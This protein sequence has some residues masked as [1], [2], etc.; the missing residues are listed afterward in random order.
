MRPNL[1]NYKND[2]GNSHC[3]NFENDKT[4]FEREQIGVKV[5]IA[6]WIEKMFSWFG[7]VE[8]VDERRFTKQNLFGDL[9]VS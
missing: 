1:N 9:G 7:Y 5:D 8:R 6:T 4:S 2:D 3:Y